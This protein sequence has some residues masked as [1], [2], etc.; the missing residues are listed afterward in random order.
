MRR[1]LL[2]A[3]L[4]ACGCGAPES[5]QAQ[6]SSLLGGGPSSTL[7]T[8]TQ[9][10]GLG[11]MEVDGQL[12]CTVSL[13][14]ARRVL[15]AAHCLASDELLSRVDVVLGGQ[16]R[17]PVVGF[18]KHPSLDVGVGVLG[19]GPP[20]GWEWAPVPLADVVGGSLVG[21]SVEAG[22]AGSGTPPGEG[23][24]FASLQVISETATELQLDAD[25][26]VGLCRGDSGGPVFHALAGGGVRL[27]ATSSRGAVDC[28]GP[29]V[30]VRTEAVGSWVGQVL[31]QSVP[32]AST[33]CVGTTA[34]ACDGHVERQCVRGWL[35]QRDCAAEGTACG[36]LGPSGELGCVPQPCAQVDYRGVC[37]GGRARYCE[38]GQVREDDCESLGLGCGL[39]GADATRCISCAACGGECVSL[40]EDLRHCGACGHACQVE[41]GEAACVAGSCTVRAC[42]DGRELDAGSCVRRAPAPGP[43]GCSSAGSSPLDWLLMACCAMYGVW[44]RDSTSRPGN[45]RSPRTLRV[46]LQQRHGA[47]AL[48]P[49]DNKVVEPER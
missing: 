49:H 34:A 48:G 30:V 40:E 20:P 2:L 12:R 28:L 17:L 38:A 42:A 6:R 18:Q 19:A 3:V 21:E 44:V 43:S 13:L 33:A 46:A 1:G 35:R 10:G 7:L 29:D 8:D 11:R 26:G 39:T 14:D 9:R 5:P 36:V 27:L 31:T 45:D 47:G 23:L 25:G 32:A 15:T 37:S 24:H 22:G 41:G 4:F 16:V